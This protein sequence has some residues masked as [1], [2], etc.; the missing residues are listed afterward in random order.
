[1]ARFFFFFLS[2]HAFTRNV[3]DANVTPTH[4]C[5]PPSRAAPS[6]MTPGITAAAREKKGRPL[7]KVCRA[8][9]DMAMAR[10]PRDR[11]PLPPTPKT[12]THLGAES[13]EM[14]AHRASRRAPEKDISEFR[15]WA[16]W[17]SCHSQRSTRLARVSCW[18]AKP[19][20]GFGLLA[21]GNPPVLSVLQLAHQVRQ[22]RW[23]WSQAKLG[24][25]KETVFFKKKNSGTSSCRAKLCGSA[26]NALARAALCCWARANFFFSFEA[27][28]ASDMAHTLVAQVGRDGSTAQGT[29]GRGRWIECA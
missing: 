20:C 22:A 3:S 13:C 11:P 1:M 19:H 14:R 15:V 24:R 21:E 23:L 9:A 12:Q 25:G 5:V 16:A 18:S 26:Q 29:S 2:P 6:P 27:S 7:P 8:A 4:S 17:L 28:C 10:P